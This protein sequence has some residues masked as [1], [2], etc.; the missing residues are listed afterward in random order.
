MKFPVDKHKAMHIGGKRKKEKK[1]GINITYKMMV[2]ELIIT[3][4][5]I[6]SWLVIQ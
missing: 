3:T 5:G 1:K 4:E 2:S 6:S